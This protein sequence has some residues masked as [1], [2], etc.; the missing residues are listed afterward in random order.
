MY[1]LVLPDASGCVPI[2]AQDDSGNVTDVKA[3]AATAF[4]GRGALAMT[5]LLPYVAS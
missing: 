3:F 4:C 5:R 2:L 1:R